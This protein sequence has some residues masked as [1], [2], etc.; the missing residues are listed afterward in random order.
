MTRLAWTFC[1]GVLASLA[2]AGCDPNSEATAAL[3][4]EEDAPDETGSADA[5]SESARRTQASVERL[6]RLH[7]HTTARGRKNPGRRLSSEARAAFAER[8]VDPD[9]LTFRFT[10]AGTPDSISAPGLALEA[11]DLELPADT[12]AKALADGFVRR[13]SGLWNVAPTAFEDATVE[14]EAAKRSTTTTVHYRQFHADLPVVG[15]HVAV[16]LDTTDPAAPA[17]VGVSGA[18][19]A[20]DTV[21]T[22]ASIEAPLAVAGLQLDDGEKPQEPRLTVWSGSRA[23]HDAEPRLAW[24][25]GIVRDDHPVRQVYVDAHDGTSLQSEPLA[26]HSLQRSLFDARAAANSSPYSC[27]NWASA[28]SCGSHCSACV[29]DPAEC[30]LC[31]CP[32]AGDPADCD[33]Q[34]WRYDESTGCLADGSPIGETDC[35][36]GALSLWSDAAA[37]HGYWATAFG[38]DSWDDA[39]GWMHLLPNVDPLTNYFGGLAYGRD[40][41]ADGTLDVASVAIRSGLANPQLHGHEFGHLLQF[42]TRTDDGVSFH[43]QG[44]DAMEHNADVHGFRMRGLGL[45]PG[46]DCGGTDLFHYTRFWSAGTSQANKYIGNCHGWLMHQPSGGT[47]HY[48]VSVIPQSP[49]VY[50]QT[51]FAALG[52]FSTSD[53]YFDWWNDVVQAASD[54]YG[55][56]SPYFTAL[57]A[58]DAIGGWTDHRS[59]STGVQPED[60]YAAASVQ[61]NANTPCVFY[62]YSGTTSTIAYSCR[63]GAGWGPYANFNDPSIDPAASEPTATYRY[64]SGSTLIY[65]AWA[66]TDDRIHYRTLDP[67]TGTVGAPQDLGTNHLTRGAVAI[68][69]VYETGVL[70]RVVVVYHPLAHPTWFYSTYIGSTS[71]AVDMGA[72]FDSDADPALTPFPYYSRLYFVRP[73]SMTGATPGRL[74][75]SSYTLA[76]GW[77]PAVDLTALYEADPHIDSAE[78]RSDRGVALTAYGRTSDR[79]R[80]TW[81]TPSSAEIWYATLSE[82]SPG[83]LER[84]GYRAVPLSS[85]E[86]A[87]RSAGG[88]VAG[89]SGSPMF[90][91]TGQGS[92]TA[93]KLFE[94]RTHSD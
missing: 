57:E 35:D 55:Y 17:I 94:W 4:L 46:Y 67:T 40:L 75:Y 10:A 49:A 82:S 5:R 64:A 89:P 21:E 13:F 7:A 28:A 43:G 26:W 18:F 33:D 62:R 38:R 39:G 77:E 66:G 22:T 14:V 60:R 61:G 34:V 23:G 91:F 48:G 76:G 45:G 42:G 24:R 83:V 36:P 41:D 92:S 44:K 11:Q 30:A 16:R 50:D 32:S 1:G 58:R 80:M 63:D 81:V 29:T 74:R 73:D 12:S 78:V 53:G 85:T 79:L 31:T 52:H 70:D 88:L 8:G 25:V 93:P 54:V 37:A 69:P 84:D 51:W 90:H 20:T 86:G 9:A 56:T 2:I 3:E 87:A 59:V 65:V 19:L 15:G 68:A 6:E 47:T 27:Q 71:A 72:A